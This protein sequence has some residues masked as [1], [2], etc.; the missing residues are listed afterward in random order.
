MDFSCHLPAFWVEVP[1]YYPY[2]RLKNMGKLL[3]QNYA[4][5]QE[6]RQVQMFLVVLCAVLVKLDNSLFQF[7]LLLSGSV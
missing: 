5:Y 4:S 7:S 1:S 2:W 6:M 3:R